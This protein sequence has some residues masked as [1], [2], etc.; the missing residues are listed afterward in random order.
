MLPKTTLWAAALALLLISPLSAADKLAPDK[1]AYTLANRTPE[2]QLRELNTDRPDL[3]ESPYTVDAGWWQLEMDIVS[4]TRDHDTARGADVKAS[5]LSFANLNLKVG[6]TSAIDLQTVFAP[7]TR[8]KAHDRIAGTQ[9]SISGFG[10]IT[11]RLKINFRGNDG[12]E[13]AF[14]L[15]PFVKWPTNQH[16]LGNR[17]V[18]GGL[19]FPCAFEL[20]NG[21]DLGA[22]TELDLVRNDT[23]HGYTTEWVNSVTLGHDLAGKLGVYI[24]LATILKS[25]AD[26]ASFDCGLTYGVGKHVQFDLGANFGLTGAA[27][28]LAVF[29]G[30]SIR[31]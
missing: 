18:E 20:P 27:D 31:F 8:V 6:L 28:D 14:G 22:M 5:A 29:T 16:G 13:S 30:L 3:T 19:I 7:S 17:S 25:G 24:E 15:M 26:V 9:S 23:D 12:G 2:T 4:Y 1:S 11:S 21:W 10:D